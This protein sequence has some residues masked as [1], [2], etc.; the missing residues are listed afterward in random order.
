[1]RRSVTLPESFADEAELDAFLAEPSPALIRLMGRLEGDILV[2]GAAGKMGVTLALQA[3]R[4]ADAA[5]A[6]KM[7]GAVSRFSDPA[8][9]RRLEQGGCTTHAC[10]L[11]D[12]AQVA[13]LPRFENVVF[14]AGRKFGTTGEAS[15]TWAANTL[16]PGHVAEHFHRSRIVA[17]S[18]GCVYPLVTAK[19][20][21]SVETDPPEPLGEYAQSCLGR[22]RV[23][24]YYSRHHHLPVCLLRL[25]YAIDL[26]YGVLHDLA[27]Q[28][29]A[30]QPVDLGMGSFNCLWQGDATAWALQALELCACPPTIL[31]LT[32]PEILSV[33]SVAHQLA[34]VLHQPVRFT[35]TEQNTAYL[36]NATIALERFGP[37]TV[38]VP[39]MMRWTASWLQ[40]GG[41]SLGQPTH[42][43]TRDGSF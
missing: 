21:G 1:M 39:T 13:D 40:S 20:G 18:T 5:G 25:N 31:N 36:N 12:R 14:M 19:S 35:G 30:D 32:G 6:A 23:F 26:R 17:F 41:R 43:S 2:L 24:E 22:E 29:L 27:R 34:E 28:I 38:P 15:L 42:F 9:R 37:P 8:A 16:L 11:L 4:A 7:I 10:D 33:R 3:R